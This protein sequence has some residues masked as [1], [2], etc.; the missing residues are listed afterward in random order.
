[1]ATKQQTNQ[2]SDQPDPL[3]RADKNKNDAKEKAANEA[4]LKRQEAMAKQVTYLIGPLSHTRRITCAEV[5]KD[6]YR[7]NLLEKSKGTE[8]EFFDEVHITHSWM[9]WTKGAEIVRS[10]GD[11][12]LEP[13][14]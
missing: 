12:P 11:V 4:R 10:A 14:K 3:P 8:S 1:M 2:S 6:R 7:I 9:V 13:L 5:G